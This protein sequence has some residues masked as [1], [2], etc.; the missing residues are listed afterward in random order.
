MLQICVYLGNLRKILSQR[1][2]S[3]LRILCQ[4]IH[5]SSVNLQSFDRL[6]RWGRMGKKNKRKTKNKAK[7]S[8]SSTSTSSSIPSPISSP[9]AAKRPI[10]RRKMLGLL[11]GVPLV[12]VAGVG[13][14]RHDVKKRALHDLSV[15]GNGSPAIVQIHDPGCR[16]CRRLMANTKNCLLYTSPSPRDATLSRMP[17]SA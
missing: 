15:L 13:V 9:V 11:L 5:L 14:H 12:G 10:S 16:L 6:I 1:Q 2:K 7:A 8:K 3:L 4:I 17:S